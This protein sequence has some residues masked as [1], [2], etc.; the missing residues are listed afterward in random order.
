MV[1]IP[2]PSGYE[3]PALTTELK[4]PE[5]PS[6]KK[7]NGDPEGN[8]TP[9]IA[10]K[11]RC[12]DLLTTGPYTYAEKKMV[13]VKGFEP[14]TPCSQSTCA[15]KLRYTPSGTIYPFFLERLSQAR[16][17]LYRSERGLS[18]GF[19]HFFALFSFF[20]FLHPHLFLLL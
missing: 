14:P 9:V 7:K 12:L 15:T 17:V 8:R 19:L 6:K 2:G 1:S 20:L 10:V 16:V 4:A 18:T 5:E 11:G 13:G 3:P